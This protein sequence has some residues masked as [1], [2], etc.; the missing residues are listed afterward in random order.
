MAYSLSPTPSRAPIYWIEAEPIALAQDRTERTRTDLVTYAAQFISSSLTAGEE[1][2]SKLPY[3]LVQSPL[4][5]EE[6][7]KRCQS[8]KEQFILRISSLLQSLP[9][10]ARLLGIDEHQIEQ[11]SALT[12]Q[13]KQFKNAP[14]QDRESQDQCRRALNN[15][16]EQISRHLSSP[17]IYSQKLKKELLVAKA[18]II[19]LSMRAKSLFQETLSSLLSDEQLLPVKQK[20]KTA[21]LRREVDLFSIEMNRER[22]RILKAAKEWYERSDF[23]Y[24][25]MD[26]RNEGSLCQ[27]TSSFESMGPSYPSQ[28]P[29]N[30][31]QEEVT[32]INYFKSS[33]SDRAD[34]PLHLDMEGT[35]SGT[36]SESNQ[37]QKKSRI[38]CLR[39]TLEQIG[40][41]H[42]D[43]ALQKMHRTP[44][45]HLVGEGTKEKPYILPLTLVTLLTSDVLIHI[46]TLLHKVPQADDG[47]LHLNELC[48]L[49]EEL[50][51]H[52]L[53]VQSGT[54]HFL[55][56]FRY[57]NL[58]SKTDYDERRKSKGGRLISNHS[59]SEQLVQKNTRTLLREANAILARPIQLPERCDKIQAKIQAKTALR[60]EMSACIFETKS[61]PPQELIDRWK[62]LSDDLV[63][64]IDRTLVGE[65]ELRSVCL[66]TSLIYDLSSD[67]RELALSNIYKDIDKMEQNRFGFGARLL[68]LSSLLSHGVHFSCNSGKDRT[69]LLDDE[70]KLLLGETSVGER[71]PAWFEQ[72]HFRH[73]RLNRKNVLEQ[74]G[75]A[76][77]NPKANIGNVAWLN[78]RGNKVELPEGKT[79]EERQEDRALHETYNRIEAASMITMKVERTNR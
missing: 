69:G 10:N 63:A 52:H 19:S 55:I 24:Q 12:Q 26:R 72:L 14:I 20:E 73:H 5:K 35:R 47:R 21:L 1:L 56:D 50:A 7:Q 9:T 11:Y 17:L 46:K 77:F 60:E 13:L 75:N 49:M 3:L 40:Q 25:I 79:E 53:K 33:F 59:K 62:E 44:D 30:R 74:A 51:D 45:F 76:L 4:A 29:R 61:L 43:L 66:R 28:L 37:T 58:P 71:L 22:S 67:I 23:S 41:T 78:L 38:A 70:W 54:H 18:E 16:S 34:S 64:T 2:F 6:I 15:L 39:H 32:A 68:M 27:F 8:A 48:S 42:A 31:T 36:I 57:F 65:E